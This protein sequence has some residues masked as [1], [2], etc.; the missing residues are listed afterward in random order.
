M[1]W[2]GACINES[3]YVHDFWLPDHSSRSCLPFG[4]QSGNAIQLR[5]D[6]LPWTGIAAGVFVCTRIEI[7]AV[8][9]LQQQRQGINFERDWE[10]EERTTEGRWRICGFLF[11]GNYGDNGGVCRKMVRR[12]CFSQTGEHDVVGGHGSCVEGPWRMRWVRNHCVLGSRRVSVQLR[13]WCSSTWCLAAACF[14]RKSVFQCPYYVNQPHTH[15]HKRKRD[16]WCVWER[17]IGV[18]S[19]VTI[20]LLEMKI[21]RVGEGKSVFVWWCD[22]QCLMMYIIMLR[23]RLSSLLSLCVKQ[24]VQVP[25]RDRFSQ[26]SPAPPS[27]PQP[28]PPSPH[29]AAAAWLL[30]NHNAACQVSGCLRPEAAAPCTPVRLW[31]MQQ[32]LHQKLA[33]QGSSTNTHR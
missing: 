15:T 30:S 32:S 29:S 9:Q 16:S 7:G 26:A 14:A 20:S 5:V 24:T 2:I 23:C 11:E 22:V 4:R 6:L 10:R 19:F 27:P 31:G 21:I 18:F 8:S 25:W 12:V 33:P 13:F 1:Q 28:L 17:E 3:G